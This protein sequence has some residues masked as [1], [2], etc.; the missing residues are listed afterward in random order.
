MQTNLSVMAFRVHRHKPMAIS[1][2]RGPRMEADRR[3]KSQVTRLGKRGERECAE[4]P[5]LEPCQTTIFVGW[6]PPKASHYLIHL[7]DILGFWAFTRSF[8]EEHPDDCMLQSMRDCASASPSCSANPPAAS[9]LAQ[10]APRSVPYRAAERHT[11]LPW[12]RTPR[13]GCQIPPTL[14][15][16]PP[17]WLSPPW[18][19]CKRDADSHGSLAQAWRLH[20]SHHLRGRRGHRE[21]PLQRAPAAAPPLQHLESRVLRAAA[22][23]AAWLAQA[24]CAALLE[25]VHRRR[26]TPYRPPQMLASKGPSLMLSHKK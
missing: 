16:H 22:V 6:Q 15:Q 2:S 11:L 7:L 19:P 12:A 3:L 5:A 26:S 1:K 24:S 23:V 10:P 20:A 21:P 17:A 18:G 25:E 4:V 13:L 14:D 8:W 9:L